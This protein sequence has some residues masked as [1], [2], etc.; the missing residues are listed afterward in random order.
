MEF[1][2]I[3]KMYTMIIVWINYILCLYRSKWDFGDVGNVG[4][5]L[6]VIGWTNVVL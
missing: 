2:D 4:W 3:L 1:I 6:A 5:L